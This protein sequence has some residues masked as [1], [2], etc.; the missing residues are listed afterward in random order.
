MYEACAEGTDVEDVHEVQLQFAAAQRRGYPT[1]TRL[2]GPAA[3][4]VRSRYE[5]TCPFFVIS[6]RLLMPFPECL[7]STYS[8]TTA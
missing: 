7:W 5:M 2:G 3:R 1:A 8:L 4:G 6:L